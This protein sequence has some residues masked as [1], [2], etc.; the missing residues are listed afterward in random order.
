MGRYKNPMLRLMDDEVIKCYI[1]PEG[2]LNAG[3]EATTPELRKEVAEKWCNG[4]YEHHRTIAAR[5]GL[6]P[7]ALLI[8]ALIDIGHPL[9]MSSRG[10]MHNSLKCSII[11]LKIMHA[12]APVAQPLDVKTIHRLPVER[13]PKKILSTDSGKN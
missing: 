4:D 2:A 13:I 7:I 1:H 12:G 9:I 6:V 10:M 8:A 3:K 11:L 5:E